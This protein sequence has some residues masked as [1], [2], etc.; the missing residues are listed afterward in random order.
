MLLTKYRNPFT[1]TQLER[2]LDKLFSRPFDLWHPSTVE[3]ACNTLPA[4]LEQT[5][6]GYLLTIT[7]PNNTTKENVSMSFEDSYLT[8]S[9]QQDTKQ[10]NKDSK[11]I[12]RERVCNKHS[13]SFYFP[14]VNKSDISATVVNGE[15][16]ISLNKAKE[17]DNNLIPIN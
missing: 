11:Y 13:R 10:E 2:Q 12:Y 16:K 1:L 7:L 17:S 14:D 15:L 9:V 4:D 5:D 3:S 8:V 6:N